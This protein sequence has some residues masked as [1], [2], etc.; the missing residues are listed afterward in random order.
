MTPS[1]LMGKKGG[2]TGGGDAPPMAETDATN[3]LLPV[4]AVWNVIFGMA[5]LF[6]TVG[7]VPIII[8]QIGV[9]EYGV[10]QVA[11]GITAFFALADLSLGVALT[12]SVAAARAS[13]HESVVRD[14]IRTGLFLFAA[15]GIAA[16]VLVFLLAPLLTR[17]FINSADNSPSGGLT[18][19]RLSGLALLPL[20][21]TTFVIGASN[22][23]HRFLV[24][25]ALNSGNLVLTTTGNVAL[26]LAGF[27]VPALLAW[28][29]LT[30]YLTLIPLFKYL[31]RILPP[32]TL[33]LSS[34]RL[35]G[36]CVS[37]LLTFSTFSWVG[38]VAGAM[39][40]TAD[41]LVVSAILGVAAVPF[42]VVPTVLTRAVVGVGSNL[43]AV[44][45]PMVSHLDARHDPESVR[46]AY[47]KAARVF[48][49]IAAGPPVILAVC[50]GSIL[51]IWLGPSFASASSTVL[52][53]GSVAAS[54]VLCTTV[55]S[56]V[57][58]GMG[59]PKLTG[60]CRLL[61]NAIGLVIC[62]PLTKRYGV[63]G[64]AVGFLLPTIVIAP[65]FVRVVERRLLGLTFSSALKT[66]IRPVMV[67]IV[68]LLAGL[69]TVTWIAPNSALGLLA[70][71]GACGAWYV[72]AVLLIR[73][74]PPA[75]LRFLGKSV[76]H[77][78]RPWKADRW[79]LR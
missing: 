78:V 74:V 47:H 46:R 75:E 30:S 3:E 60:A 42:Y 77:I 39:A 59:R 44:L 27:D 25:A 63:G 76:R 9:S 51:R 32:G 31:R 71:L 57:A 48:A 41:R 45:F 49:T 52:I 26:A 54:V 17:E 12:K 7:L 56:Y 37:T 28:N 64:T 58:D 61:Q 38:R 40:N 18:S 79:E 23:M 2:G 4:K 53:A 13:G 62:V 69:K 43:G 72:M 55:A 22:G 36:A 20:F 5:P 11:L 16:S 50:S 33:I 73:P 10:L 6:V 68:V 8:R 29:A 19:V 65:A 1:S 70:L 67:G 34:V 21:L 15:I 35:S 14:L 66:Y 24:P